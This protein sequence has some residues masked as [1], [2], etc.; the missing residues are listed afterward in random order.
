MTVPPPYSLR[1][2]QL[3]REAPGAGPVPPGPGA[4]HAAEAGRLMEDAWVRLE[5]R[6]EGGR[7]L[8]A[9]FRAWGCPHLIAA[10]ALAAGRLP[11]MGPAEMTGLDAQLL[12]AELDVPA[13]KLGRLLKVEDCISALA[14]RIA[15][16]GR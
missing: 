7:V 8:A 5:V 15:A 13:A 3:F 12:A 2:L 10:A 16:A 9:G 4:L 6:A 1:V 11:G 14:A